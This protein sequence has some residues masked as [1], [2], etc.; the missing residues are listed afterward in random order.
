MYNS[1]YFLSFFI[2]SLAVNAELLWSQI[3]VNPF[4]FELKVVSSPVT[5]SKEASRPSGLPLVVT[6]VDL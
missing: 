3:T 4:L 1:S 5:M 6:C 2:K